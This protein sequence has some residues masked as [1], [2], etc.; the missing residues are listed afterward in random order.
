MDAT[1]LEPEEVNGEEYFNSSVQD[2]HCC[3]Q[4]L[5]S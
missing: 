5:W 3:F 2:I 4:D 1:E